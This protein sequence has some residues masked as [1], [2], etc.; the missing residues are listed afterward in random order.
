M[1]L[2]KITHSKGEIKPLGSVLE[3]YGKSGKLRPDDASEHN[4]E[5]MRREVLSINQ[6][7]IG[8]LVAVPKFVDKS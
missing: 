4:K 1:D 7:K 8:N 6:N 5:K 3:Y 2:A